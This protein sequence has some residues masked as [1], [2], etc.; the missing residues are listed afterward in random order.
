M[1]DAATLDRSVPV[2]Q[3]KGQLYEFPKGPFPF[4]L[5]EKDPFPFYL[6]A[7]LDQIIQ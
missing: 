4:F 3:I 1:H 2:H 5:L 6:L 7:G